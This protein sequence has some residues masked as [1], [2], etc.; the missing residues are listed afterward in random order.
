[1][2]LTRYVTLSLLAFIAPALAEEP[3]MDVKKGMA[4]LLDPLREIQPYLADQDEFID[5]ANHDKIAS[6]L[7]KLQDDFHG[8][9]TV[10]SRFHRYPGFD[11]NLKM[12]TEL[13]QD[14]NRR[15][16]EGKADY[17][18]WRARV[19][20]GACFACHATYQVKTTYSNTAVIDPSLD[21]ISRARF[22][23]AT[24]QFPEAEKALLDILN[25]P[26]QRFYFG[27]ALRS[28][29]IVETRIKQDPAASA[30][31][32]SKVLATSQLPEDDA[33]TVK[34]W[35]ETFQ[36]WAKE[37]PSQNDQ[38]LA[39]AERLMASGLA[40]DLDYESNDVA[41]LRGTSIVH[42]ILEQESVTP[43]QRRRG[44]YLLGFAYSRLPLFF[45]EGWAEMYLE[46]CITE[47]PGTD[48]AKR[49]FRVYREHVGD[50]FTG[51]GGTNI[52]GEIELQ[53][54]TLRKKAF[55]IPDLDGKV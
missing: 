41:L 50:D 4:S 23:L 12:V 6:L 1:M 7:G 24:R 40:N 53:I 51:S 47:F 43:E 35:I 19:L 21:P 32:F 14:S 45:T 27:E 5:P 48:D 25:D 42:Q 44:L 52:P 38:T 54:D 20:P 18:W 29:I 15:F 17:A 30:A 39:K 55:G 2:K 36:A 46:Q 16:K 22:L 31:T 11:H 37:K 10:P 33:Q 13:L 26:T 8:L 28:L 3:G 34:R 49:A 9:E